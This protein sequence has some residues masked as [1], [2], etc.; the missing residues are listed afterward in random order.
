MEKLRADL[1]LGGAPQNYNPT[2][3]RMPERLLGDRTTIDFLLKA[4]YAPTDPEI[5]GLKAQGDTASWAIH[6]LDQTAAD[7]ALDSA[8]AS[9]QTLMSGLT[10]KWFDL[11]WTQ[12]GSNNTILQ[13]WPTNPRRSWST[14]KRV[15]RSQPRTQD[16]CDSRSPIPR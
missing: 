11:R 2:L 7:T 15:W 9:A 5:T 14:G 6:N 16:T 4:G 13:S 3:L 1:E 10:T 8:E 12:G